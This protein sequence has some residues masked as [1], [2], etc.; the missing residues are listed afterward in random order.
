M[1]DLGVDSGHEDEGVVDAGDVFS[2]VAQGFCAAEF[3][4]ADEGGEF[5]AKG[6]EEVGFGFEAVVGGI[7][8]DG[9]EVATGF[10][11]FAE[12]VDLGGGRGATGEDSGDDHEAI[13]P[14]FTGVGGVGGGDGGVL[15][16]SAYDGGDA[17]IYKAADAF[18]ALVI[19][20][21]GP[22]AHGSAVDDAAHALVDEALGGFDEGVVVDGAVLI[23]R[24]HECGDTAF[25]DGA[26][27]HVETMGRNWWAVL[28]VWREID[29]DFDNRKWGDRIGP[30]KRERGRCRRGRVIFT[31]FQRRLWC[32]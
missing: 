6:E 19:G 7:V 24:G 5:F 32:R 4:E 28:S 2:S 14:Y 21:E 30:C 10:E 26:G 23:A 11:D 22:V 16:S 13:G 1:E 12:V 17:G 15:S 20:K 9:G 25:E 29:A 31:R 27:G 3:L 18:H 8:N